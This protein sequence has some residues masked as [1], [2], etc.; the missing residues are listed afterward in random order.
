MVKIVNTKDL[1]KNYKVKM[2]VYGAP[3]TGKTLLGSTFPNALIFETE[4]GVSTLIDSGADV[5]VVK[6]KSIDEIKEVI[7]K[8]GSKYDSFVFDSVTEL[9]KNF[10]RSVVGERKQPS[11][12]DWGVGL[13]DLD[14]VLRTFRDAKKHVLFIFGETEVSHE[15][16]LKKRLNISGSKTDNTVCGY[17][18][19]VGYMRKEMVEDTE[20]FYL[21]VASKDESVYTKSRFKKLRETRT[22]E[23]PAFDKVYNLIKAK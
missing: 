7:A 20:K 6:V 15:N 2:V 22:I 18:D 13:S 3:G 14:S 1:A 16:I 19:I 5:D 4:N 23:N 21:D 11:M 10:M 17:V 12:R 8:Y 9:L